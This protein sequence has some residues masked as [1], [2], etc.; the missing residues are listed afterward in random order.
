MKFQNKRIGDWATKCAVTLTS[1]IL[2]KLLPVMLFPPPPRLFY[3]EKPCL[4][5]VAQ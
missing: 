3:K 1:F 4:A 5:G 2:L